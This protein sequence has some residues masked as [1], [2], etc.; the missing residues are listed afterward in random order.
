MRKL[1]FMKARMNL[2]KF[3]ILLINILQVSLFFSTLNPF[4]LC[5][6]FRGD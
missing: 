5:S 2:E 3:P 4:D 6:A 1:N